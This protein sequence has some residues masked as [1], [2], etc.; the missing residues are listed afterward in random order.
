MKAE[1]KRL[2]VIRK[3][4][5]NQTI[6][7][8]LFFY[9]DSKHWCILDELKQRQMIAE[10]SCKDYRSILVIIQNILKS[11]MMKYR[12]L[13]INNGRILILLFTV[14]LMTM[15]WMKKAEFT[16]RNSVFLKWSKLFKNITLK[17]TQPW[18]TTAIK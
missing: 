17:S 12:A 8:V 1:S 16:L 6:I 7:S 5:K 18:M 10:E 2:K 14:F 9:G 11:I 15:S 3:P 13:W 4:P